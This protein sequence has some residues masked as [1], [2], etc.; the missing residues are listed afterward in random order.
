MQ[1][2]VLCAGDC[3]ASRAAERLPETPAGGLAPLFDTVVFASDYLWQHGALWRQCELSQKG[4]AKAEKILIVFSDGADTV[5]RNSFAN[6][7]DAAL[8]D[9]VQV[10][11]IDL[12]RSSSQGAGVLYRPAD[13]TGGRHFSARDR[14][15]PR[16]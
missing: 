8:R 2:A 16:A 1:P 4:D 14:G 9:E 6:A 3:R 7:V 13:A 10:F 12:N 5:S 15:Q 11:S